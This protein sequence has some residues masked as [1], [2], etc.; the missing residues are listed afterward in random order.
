MV[1]LLDA[2]AVDDDLGSPLASREEK[3]LRLAIEL[4]RQTAAGVS[5]AAAL[6]ALERGGNYDDALLVRL[7]NFASTVGVR[8]PL[9]VA[10]PDESCEQLR[11]AG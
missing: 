2:M 4:E 6:T 7:R 8:E 9:L 1:A 3:A 11:P 10:V 5:V